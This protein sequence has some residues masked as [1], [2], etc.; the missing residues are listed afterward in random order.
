MPFEENKKS[1]MDTLFS[2]AT[3]LKRWQVEIQKKDVTKNYM[4]KRLGQW[5]E[6]LESLRHEIMMSKD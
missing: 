2:I 6:Q 5:I 1:Y 3:L 4:L